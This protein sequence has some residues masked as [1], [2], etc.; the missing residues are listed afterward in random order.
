MSEFPP[1]PSNLPVPVDDGAAAHLAGMRVPSIALPATSGALVD[2]ASLRGRSVIFA[3]PR[4]SRPGQPQLVPDWDMIPGARG[5]NRQACSFR[6][7][8]A[9]F[10]ELGARIFGLSTQ[11]KDDQRETAEQM[12]LPFPLLSEID[13]RLATAMRLPTFEVAGLILLK[14]LTMILHDGIVERVFYPVFPT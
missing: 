1:L 4:T 7:L 14:R 6:D 13:L 3:Y 11:S 2:L 12:H 9:S 8:S 5:C 10:A